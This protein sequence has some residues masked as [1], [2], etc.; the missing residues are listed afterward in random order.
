[1]PEI[2]RKCAKSSGIFEQPINK[3]TGTEH[4]DNIIFDL[5]QALQ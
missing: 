3:S 4:I 5:E 1:M 2:F